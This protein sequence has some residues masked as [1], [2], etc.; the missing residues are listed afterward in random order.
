MQNL[1]LWLSFY[2][3]W[4]GAIAYHLAG[5]MLYDLEFQGDNF[6]KEAAAWEPAADPPA[7]LIIP[8]VK[9]VQCGETML[10]GYNVN[11]GTQGVKW[12]RTYENVPSHTFLQMR[13]KIYA[14]D[15][16]D[17]NL[18]DPPDHLEIYIDQTPFVLWTLRRDDWV[19][20]S[21]NYCGTTTINRKDLAPGDR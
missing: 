14:I 10:G 15:T 19:D 18:N 17:G 4:F 8:G 5:N 16:W 7:S 6:V 3:C 20:Q 2:C 12:V 11:S 1:L 13:I 21:V 9:T